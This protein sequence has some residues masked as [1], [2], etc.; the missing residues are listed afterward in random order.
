MRTLVVDAPGVLYPYNQ[1]PPNCDPIPSGLRLVRSLT[2]GFGVSVLVVGQNPVPNHEDS[3]KAWLTVY[4][5]THT[6]LETGDEELDHVA[7]WERN[8]LTRL[9]AQQAQP[10]VIISSS[11]SVC[12]MLSERSVATIQFRPPRGL[13]PDW[14]P[15]KSTWASKAPPTEE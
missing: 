7:F 9:G 11:T 14:G 13:A 8:V 5:V 2:E 15:M 1:Y 12:R 4:D 3:L 10:P 6:W